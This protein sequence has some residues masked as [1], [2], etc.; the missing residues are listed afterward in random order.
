[1]TGRELEPKTKPTRKYFVLLLLFFY[2]F[3]LPPFRLV[4]IGVLAPRNTVVRSQEDP[5][6]STIRWLL[7]HY[8]LRVFKLP[9]GRTLLDVFSSAFFNSI[10]F[11]YFITIMVD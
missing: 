1:M 4:Y 6:V 9:L 10:S 3:E 2:S 5:Q 7:V 8:A 11:Q